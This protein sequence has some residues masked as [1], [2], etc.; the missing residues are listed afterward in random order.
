MTPRPRVPGYT[1]LRPTNH[2]TVRDGIVYHDH[3]ARRHAD[4]ALRVL[5]VPSHRIGALA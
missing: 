3:V 4:G 5:L 1:L 2:H